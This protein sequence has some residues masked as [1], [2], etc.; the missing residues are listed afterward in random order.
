M[1]GDVNG[2]N[3]GDFLIS[4]YKNDFKMSDSGRAYLFYG[5]TG[6][7]A[8]S[9]TKSLELGAP[10]ADVIFDTYFSNFRL[11]TDLAP[12]GD[13]TGDG[14]N[15]IIIGAEYYDRFNID[16]LGCNPDPDI[17]PTCDNRDEGAALVWE[18]GSFT[19]HRQFDFTDG[20]T[21]SLAARAVLLGE[22]DQDRIGYSI[23]GVGDVNGDGTNDFVVGSPYYDGSGTDAGVVYVV[24]G[25]A[26]GVEDLG[27]SSFVIAKI[28]GTNSNE[29]F[30][31]SVGALGDINGDGTN[32][33]VVGA[34]GADQNGADS[35]G[36]FIF[37]GPVSGTFNS[38]T[39]DSIFAGANAGDEV[40]TGV[41]TV[42]DL[43]AG[44]RP[45]LLIGAHHYTSGSTFQGGAFVIL[46]ENY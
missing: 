2:D 29:S 28:I 11:G 43:D 24:S 22:N 3:I 44:G 32:D 15:D 33:F 41:V 17:N 6:T 20:D 21:S 36:A 1:V 23:H 9:G 5:A 19:S 14:I 18:G 7:D 10:P 40:G 37:L 30:G 31:R 12:A 16:G 8:L 13:L 26:T 34:K 35:G 38:N 4:A 46:G 42:G 45:D 39:A 27:S 25:A